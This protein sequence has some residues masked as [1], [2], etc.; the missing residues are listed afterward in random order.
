MGYK[1]K[2]LYYIYYY[3]SIGELNNNYVGDF[4]EP[5]QFPNITITHSFV[6]NNG[7]GDISLELAVSRYF[8]S[9]GAL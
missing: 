7:E 6:S 4:R 9:R 3:M 2:I 1:Y 8:T 5:T